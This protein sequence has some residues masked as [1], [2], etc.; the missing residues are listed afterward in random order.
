MADELPIIISALI[1]AVIGS[2][3][4]AV[5]TNL[6][7]SRTEKKRSY[8]N[9][10]QRYLLQLQDSVESIWFRF[11]NIKQRGGRKVMKDTYY[12]TTT[13]YALAKVLAVKHIIIVEGVYS[14]IQKR[15]TG[16]GNLSQR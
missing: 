3:G 5:V 11:V 1:G 4:S 7:T 13:L 16:F 12:E 10:V 6:L 14:K 2:I 8:E 9:L 15:Q